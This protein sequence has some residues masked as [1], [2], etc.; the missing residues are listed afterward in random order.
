[1][2]RYTLKADMAPGLVELNPITD[3]DTPSMSQG[4][5]IPPLQIGVHM[6][7]PIKHVCKV[8][9]LCPGGRDPEMKDLVPA[10]EGFRKLWEAAEWP[11]G[12]W[13]E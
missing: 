8:S 12:G 3:V 13:S 4:S 10:A 6:L 7:P 5:F 11:G 9:T 2:G 1:M